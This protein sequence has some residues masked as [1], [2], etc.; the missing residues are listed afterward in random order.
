MAKRKRKTKKIGPRAGTHIVWPKGL[1]ERLGISSP[2]RWRWEK[3]G[4]IPPRDAFI[5]GIPVGWKTATADALLDRTATA[6]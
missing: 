2:T 6:A 4:A 3:S 5:N 1:Q